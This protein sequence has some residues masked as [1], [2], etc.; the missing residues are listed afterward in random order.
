MRGLPYASLFLEVV[1]VATDFSGD[2]GGGHW[3]VRM[4]WRP[5]GW[6]MCLPLLTFPC[7]IKSRSSLLAPAHPGGPGKRAVKRMWCMW[8]CG[9][10]ATDLD[11]GLQLDEV[12]RPLHDDVVGDVEASQRRQLGQLVRQLVN[13]V[14]GHVQ[15]DQIAQLLDV[16]RQSLDIVAG[17]VQ[18]DET[19]QQ[20]PVVRDLFEPIVRQV[21]Y[22]STPTRTVQRPLKRFKEFVQYKHSL[23]S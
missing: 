15:T 6:S 4:E 16:F 13:H 3:L 19:I 23:Q 8:C 11:F 5:A 20:R 7:T 12:C 9:R 10:Y 2:G 14:V 18:L 17:D 1:S 21:Q 22:L